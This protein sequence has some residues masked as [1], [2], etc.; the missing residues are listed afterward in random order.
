MSG[1]G[2][3][4]FGVEVSQ[5]W[6]AVNKAFDEHDIPD[7]ARVAINATLTSSP[8]T[9]LSP[10]PPHWIGSTQE[11]EA[12]VQRERDAVERETAKTELLRQGAERKDAERNQE[13]LKWHEEA[14]QRIAEDK[15][16]SADR[17]AR[18]QLENAVSQKRWVAAEEIA[19]E[20][21]LDLQAMTL[22]DWHRFLE[23][24]A[25]LKTTKR[26]QDLDSL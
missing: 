8:G 17:F 19:A 12:A 25:P 13:Q 23:S 11:L 16:R 7:A 10:P 3:L 6:H 1:P 5:F 14:Q 22:D 18:I 15:Q 20:K 26:E 21:G 9:E 24:E 2:N 4:K